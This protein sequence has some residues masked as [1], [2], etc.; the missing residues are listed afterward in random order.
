[1]KKLIAFG[2]SVLL[3]ALVLAGCNNPADEPLP[4]SVA[5]EYIKGG[6]T[7]KLTI[8]QSTA[9]ATYTPVSGD[10]Y[11]LLIITGAQTKTSSGTISGFLNNTFTL[12]P[13]NS[14]VTF[15]VQ[16]SGST[17]SKISG[18]I[19]LEGSGGTLS[20]PDTASVSNAG[21]GGGGG[22]GGGSSGSGGGGGGSSAG[23]SGIDNS[24]VELA[25]LLASLPPNTPAN[26]H[27]IALNASDITGLV[28][29]LNNE[30]DKYVSL[31]LSGSTITTI[32]VKGCISLVGVTIPD[33]VT[34][35]GYD[36]FYSCT[37]LAS[38]TIPSKRKM[39]HFTQLQS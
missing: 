24:I 22:S 33:S 18:T 21:V 31:D 39:T 6:S 29:V 30:P 20:G 2:L 1:M 38:V 25:A 28:T 14:V 36:A 15:T 10:K 32:Q 16:V 35:I 9:K 23:G 8:T 19:T 34:S 26:P 17:I 27:L 11:K 5:Y 4:G 37:S 7:Y 3:L 13:S 12:K